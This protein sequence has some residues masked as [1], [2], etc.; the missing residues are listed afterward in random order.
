MPSPTMAAVT[1]INHRGGRCQDRPADLGIGRSRAP[2]TKEPGCAALPAR[3]ADLNRRGGDGTGGV[4]RAHGRHAVTHGQR[5]G[6][7]ALALAAVLI[8][9]RFVLPLELGGDPERPAEE[10]PETVKALE[11]TVVTLPLAKP[12]PLAKAAGRRPDPLPKNRPPLGALPPPGKVPPLGG[13]PEPPPGKPPLVAEPDASP[14]P[15]NPPVHLP[16]VG[17]LTVTVLAVTTLVFLEVLPE[18]VTQ[19]PAATEEAGTVTIWVKAVDV[20]QLTVT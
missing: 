9:G 4:G 17:W 2:N 18:T 16:V 5:G 14:G 3:R 11:V 6:G 10:K 7:G 20:V 8:D 15:P 12:P 1:A 19:S 13:P